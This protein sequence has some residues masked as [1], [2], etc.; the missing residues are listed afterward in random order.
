MIANIYPRYKNHCDGLD[1]GFDSFC[2][3]RRRINNILPQVAARFEF[4]ILPIT[5]IP[6]DSD[7]YYV[8]STGQLSGKG[9]KAY[10]TALDK[11]LRVADE[12]CKEK[13]KYNIVKA[14]QEN[15][16]NERRLA[17]ERNA[18]TV[19]HL[20]QPRTFPRKLDRGDHSGP[21]FRPATKKNRFN[22]GHSAHR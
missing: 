4:E 22:R 10:W 2:T 7:E 6:T 9:I 20:Q 14:H 3:K 21:D 11:E 1:K 8:Q 18:M 17:Q 5:G 16:D 13:F 12:R 19:S 15:L